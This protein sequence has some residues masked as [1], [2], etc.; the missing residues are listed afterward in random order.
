[1]PLLLKN[2]KVSTIGKISVP[3]V[4]FRFNSAVSRCLAVPKNCLLTIAS[5]FTKGCSFQRR[6]GVKLDRT[7]FESML[8]CKQSNIDSG[9]TPI[10]SAGRAPAEII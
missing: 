5:D 10:G 9:A 4:A 6:Q 1:M 3:L 2:G 8:E 7:E